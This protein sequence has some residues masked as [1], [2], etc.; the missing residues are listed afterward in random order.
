MWLPE[1]T[2]PLTDKDVN[3]GEVCSTN[4]PEPV[5]LETEIAKVPEDVIGDPVTERNDGTVNATEVTVPLGKV[6]HVIAVDP[7]PPEVKT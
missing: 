1:F 3:E 4:A 6:L 2:T 5:E 7:P